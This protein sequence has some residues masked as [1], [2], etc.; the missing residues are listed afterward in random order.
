MASVLS[1]AADLLE[2][3]GAALSGR[4]GPPPAGDPAQIV[5]NTRRHDDGGSCWRGRGG[6][7]SEAG[8]TWP[9]ALGFG[10]GRAPSRLALKATGLTL[11]NEFSDSVSVVDL[12]KANVSAEIALGKQGELRPS[13]RGE[14]LF[15]DA[16]P[17]P[18]R[19]AELP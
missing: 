17:G 6:H 1:P 19:L 4:R 15:H 3:S 18:R 16:T 9:S 13:D 10:R 14:M 12:P 2:G 11:A 7:R 8:Y 5:R